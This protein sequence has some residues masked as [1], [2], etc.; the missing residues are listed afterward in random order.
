MILIIIMSFIKNLAFP[1][2][3]AGIKDSQKD[4]ITLQ[5]SFS[6]CWAASLSNIFRYFWI[7]KTEKEIARW[8]FSTKTWT[9]I[10][11]LLRFAKY[12]N[13]DHII[14]KTTNIDEIKIPAILGV[15]F[16]S[17]GHFVTLLWKKWNELVIWEPLSWRVFMNKAEFIKRYNFTGFAVS[18]EK[19]WD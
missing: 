12:N 1:L 8:A 16:G 17:T 6:T 18:F 9:E 19:K 14:Q 13:L 11:Y 3:L 15:K 10:W 5:T 4:W 2:D 7:I